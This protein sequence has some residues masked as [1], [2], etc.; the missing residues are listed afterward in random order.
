[1]DSIAIAY[2]DQP[3]PTKAENENNA[4]YDGARNVNAYTGEYYTPDSFS[5]FALEDAS[6]LQFGSNVVLMSLGAGVNSEVVEN[7]GSIEE[8][9]RVTGGIG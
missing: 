2:V 1:M 8:F 6:A 9:L 3:G 5:L 4:P 7:W